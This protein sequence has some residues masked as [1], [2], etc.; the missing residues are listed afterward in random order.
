MAKRPKLSLIEATKIAYQDLQKSREKNNNFINSISLDNHPPSINFVKY[1]V[2]YGLKKNIIESFIP[3]VR[4]MDIDM[5]GKTSNGYLL[6][7]FLTK[8]IEVEPSLS[9]VIALELAISEITKRKIYETEGYFPWQISY[10]PSSVTK[11]DP[12]YALRYTPW[13]PNTS[14]HYV[15]INMDGRVSLSE[16]KRNGKVFF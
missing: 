8:K 15:K 9:I 1:C 2:S 12:Y 5:E 13:N 14:L 4:T 7:I 11:D 6:D 16:N 3:I 10:L